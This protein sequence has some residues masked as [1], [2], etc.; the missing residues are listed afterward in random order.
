MIYDEDLARLLSQRILLLCKFLPQCDRHFA[1]QIIPFAFVAQVFQASLHGR[2]PAYSAHR[3]SFVRDRQGASSFPNRRCDT[4]PL[5]LAAKLMQH[6]REFDLCSISCKRSLAVSMC[7]PGWLHLSGRHLSSLRRG[8]R[9]SCS[10]KPIRAVVFRVR[11]DVR[12]PRHMFCAVVAKAPC[13]EPTFL[14]DWQQPSRKFDDVRMVDQG[15][16]PFGSRQKLSAFPPRSHDWSSVHLS[17]C[18]P[19]GSCRPFAAL[20]A[21][22]EHMPI[23]ERSRRYLRCMGPTDVRPLMVAPE[24]EVP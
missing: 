9:T 23:C 15:R 21:R 22:K 1:V 11:L 16:M 18:Q 3:S 12:P 2:Q 20:A 17:D 7:P 4:N 24:R 13:P 8:C 14:V 5:L 6:R 10:K 19:S